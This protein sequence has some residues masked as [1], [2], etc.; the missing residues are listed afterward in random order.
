[1]PGQPLR[2]FLVWEP[3][4]ATDRGAPGSAVLARAPDPRVQQFWDADTVLSRTWQPV[5]RQAAVPVVGKES[6]VTGK[7]VWDVVAVCEP[8]VRWN[9]AP[10]VP[11][12]LGGPVVRVGREL[13]QHLSRG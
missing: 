11:S 12:F 4:I 7:T 8:G 10:P 5:L 3:V 9:S 6:L 13:R 2:A 1:M